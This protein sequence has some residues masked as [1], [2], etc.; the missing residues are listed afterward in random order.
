MLL[1]NVLD[2]ESCVGRLDCH[3]RVGDGNA[4]GFDRTQAAAVP[5][6]P[7]GSIRDSA[8]GHRRDRRWMDLRKI[9]PG[10]D[11]A[12][13]VAPGGVVFR[14]GIDFAAPRLDYF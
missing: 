7:E 5:G 11:R 1:A 2:R 9:R 6:P 4:H 12:L 13:R 14:A 8:Y 10:R 3:V